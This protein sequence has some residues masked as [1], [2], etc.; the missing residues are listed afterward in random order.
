M[1]D[2]GKITAGIIIFLAAV[3]APLWYNQIAGRAAHKPDLKIITKEK[4]CVETREFMRIEHMQ[5]LNDWRNRLVRDGIR[6]YISADK[7]EHIISLTGTCMRCHSNKTDFCDRCHNY[8]QVSPT[9]W[10]CHVIPK[11]NK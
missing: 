7:T 5:L 6:K 3:T 2:T 4:R 9:C 8:L 11:E 10:N 1:Y